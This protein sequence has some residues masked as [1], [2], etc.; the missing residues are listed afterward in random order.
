MKS[1]LRWKS[2]PAECL[3]YY[4]DDQGGTVVS[5][6]VGSGKVIWWADSSPLSNY[7][8]AQTS[9]LFLYLNS[10]GESKGKQVLWDEYYH[11]QRPGLWA[12]LARTPAP[13]GL[14]QAALL[15]LAVLL[16]YSRRSGPVMA[17]PRESRLSPLEFVETVGDLYARRRAAAGALEIAYH[18]FRSLLARRLGLSAEPGI[19]GVEAAIQ[20]LSDGTDPDLVPL[21]ARC[22][23]ALRVG[24]SDE[25]WALKLVQE[26]HHHTH[27]L[28][29]AGKG[30]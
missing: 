8:L 22:E 20:E 30:E 13:W 10:V 11:G 1:R 25:A 21:L 3:A 2:G 27:R 14:L 16:T 19:E 23:G 9:N 4:G 6:P 12:Y 24:N 28:R 29:L 18:R 7:G 15:V 26:L 5:W 17:T